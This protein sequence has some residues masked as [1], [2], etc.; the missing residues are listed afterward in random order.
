MFE[1]AAA[2]HA[3]QANVLGDEGLD[4]GQLKHLVANGLVGVGLYVCATA[5]AVLGRRTGDLCLGLLDGHHGAKAALVS[6]LPAR[7]FAALGPWRTRW[8]PGAVAAGG[9]G[10]VARVELEALFQLR[11]PL[12]DLSMA[13]LELADHVVT[14]N[15]R[16][17]QMGLCWRG[18]LGAVAL[19]HA[20][21]LPP[22]AVVSHELAAVTWG[23][24]TYAPMLSV[25]FHAIRH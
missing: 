15:H 17:W 24:N 23:V 13:E 3:A 22:C 5:F 4:P 6:G 25:K 18:G 16:A 14:L 1:P 2:A 8:H 21:S 10:G 9:L 7:A 11:Q 12:H 20:L 19:A